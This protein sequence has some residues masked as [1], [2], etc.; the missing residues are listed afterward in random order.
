[1]GE[2][3]AERDEDEAL[4]LALARQEEAS[5]DEANAALASAIASTSRPAPRRLREVDL[6]L[7]NFLGGAFSPGDGLA[8]LEQMIALSALMDSMETA[9]PNSPPQPQ[10]PT[11]AE[12]GR[13][14]TRHVN[15]AML[16]SMEREGAE[17]ECP[18]CFSSYNVGDELRTLPCMHAFHCECIDRWLTSGREG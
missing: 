4:A 9:L 6:E 12:I 5:N 18:V 10:R 7:G 14:P 1:M 15:S 2:E 11:A 3:E 8:D 13:L 17:S 16:E